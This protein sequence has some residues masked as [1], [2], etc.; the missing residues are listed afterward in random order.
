MHYRLS[1]SIPDLHTLEVSRAPRPPGV[2]IKQVS[3]HCQRPPLPRLQLRTTVLQEIF[4]RGYKPI[5]LFLKY[6]KTLAFEL[7]W[8]QAA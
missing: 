4:A 1:S 7:S 6:M 2:T 5:F 3:R 8:T